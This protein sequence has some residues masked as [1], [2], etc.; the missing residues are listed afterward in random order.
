M[1][2]AAGHLPSRLQGS[3]IL[4]GPKEEAA[5][6][7]CRS[8]PQRSLWA[9]LPR[10]PQPCASHLREEACRGALLPGSWR[11]DVRCKVAFKCKQEGTAGTGGWGLRAPA[12]A[13][14]RLGAAL[15]AQGARACKS[16]TARTSFLLQTNHER[17]NNKAKTK[18]TN[19]KKNK[20]H[21]KRQ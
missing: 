7:G 13:G 11:G 8:D 6:W 19:S 2:S 20:N 9:L 4:G 17:R 1:R 12:K 3:Q 15:P 14:A 21:P 18:I 5:A 10:C 16:Q